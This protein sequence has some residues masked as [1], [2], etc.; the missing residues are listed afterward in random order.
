VKRHRY[1]DVFMGSAEFTK[2]LA[3][4]MEE[5]REYYDPLGLNKMK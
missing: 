3:M 4:R 2:F 1:E 5:Y